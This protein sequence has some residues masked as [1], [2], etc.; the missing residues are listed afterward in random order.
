MLA[1]ALALLQPAHAKA[2]AEG[3]A[4][5]DWRPFDR[6]DLAAIIGDTDGAAGADTPTGD[7]RSATGLTPWGGVAV[8]QN[9]YLASVGLTVDRT[10]SWTGTVD[11]QDD[12]LQRRLVASIRPGLDY[13]RYLRPREPAGV[14][15]WVGLGASAVLPVVRYEDASLTP[16]EQADWDEAA[17]EDR[18]RLLA[19]G[20]RI[21]AGLEVGFANGLGVG[22]RLFG[23]VH[24]AQTL[25]EDTY[26]ATVRLDSDAAV[27]L[28]FTF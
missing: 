2:D 19:V 28:S 5:V 24:R 26:T 11:D 21:G 3:L 23:V 16:E 1:L 6:G 13:R 20:G 18:A 8:G 9:A 14:V 27:Y 25:D 17:R 4:G 15:P 7:S 10:L 12:T 22:A